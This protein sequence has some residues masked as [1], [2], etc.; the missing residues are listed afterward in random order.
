MKIQLSKLIL[1]YF[2]VKLFAMPRWY[3]RPLGSRTYNDY[4][5]GQMARAID[6]VKSEGY[7]QREAAAETGVKRRTLGNK[8]AGKHPGTVGRQTVLDK[9]EELAFKQHVITMSNFGFPMDTVDL[10][11]I[12]K[13]YLDKKGVQVKQ[14]KNNFPG[15]D[16]AS[17]FLNRHKDL[18]QRLAGNIK[19]KRAGISEE[20]I[21]QYF[22]N[23]KKELEG[24]PPENIMNYDETNVSDD[25]GRKRIITKRGTKYPERIMNHS[26]SCT[27]LMYAGT[28]G[29]K[30]MPPYAVYKAINMWDSWKANGYPGA[31]YNRTS[32]GWFDSNCFRD[33]F[34]TI[35][36]PYLKKLSG[37]KVLIGDNLSSHIDMDVVKECEKH[38]IKFICL[39]PFST[40]LTQP[41]DIAFFGP[42]KRKW[43]G[44][45]DAWKRED[46]RCT[47]M[48]K[49]KF[50]MRLK[51]L[52]EALLE[53]AETNLKAGFKKAGI[54][55]LDKEAVLE[56]LPQKTRTKDT[57]LVS[58]T[59]L[60][61][62]EGL[63]KSTCPEPKK[64]R[65]KVN[66]APGKSVSTEDFQ[67]KENAPPEEDDPFAALVQADERRA[68]ADN[69]S[70]GSHSD[71]REIDEESEEEDE[72]I[73]VEDDILTAADLSLE[74]WVIVMYEGSKFPGVVKNFTENGVVVNAMSKNAGVGWSWPK[75]VDQLEYNYN[76]V[77]AKLPSSAVVPAT[78]RGALRIESPHLA[79]YN[80]K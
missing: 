72:V 69:E 5:D 39:I 71:G 48:P 42:M 32:S 58:D 55:P 10:R 75:H 79:A 68:D 35:A 49:D 78:N 57:S 38:D 43:R 76:D 52:H 45:L 37:K 51:A 29:G 11:M 50:P 18:T 25:P 26:K 12:V 28:A 1:E 23:L 74:D 3:K 62:V 4:A 9:K 30:L 53:N 54:W 8:L 20:E 46:P 70:D 13:M 27:S 47:T 15:T 6:L 22:S 2:T 31:R 56:R 61:H 77:V 21:D 17:L 44:L 34:F 33:W 80:L 40:H 41:L 14:F 64:R 19:T 66:V 7:S 63:R 73:N 59:F 65:K 60:E 24:L 67:D 36:L 16:W